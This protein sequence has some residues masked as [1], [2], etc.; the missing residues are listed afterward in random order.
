MMATIRKFED[1]MI[2]YDLSQQRREVVK[3]EGMENKMWTKT[4]RIVT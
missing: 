3:T 4:A 1:F 2:A